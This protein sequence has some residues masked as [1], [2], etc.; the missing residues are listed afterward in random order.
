MLTST[1]Q[2]HST[3]LANRRSTIAIE[4]LVD[5]LENQLG[6]ILNSI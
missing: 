2:H 1:T 3:A 4:Q 6:A 5:W